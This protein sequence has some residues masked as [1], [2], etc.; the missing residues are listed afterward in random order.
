MKNHVLSPVLLN[1][2]KSF[3]TVLTEGYKVIGE[4]QRKQQKDKHQ[5]AQMRTSYY[6]ITH[7]AYNR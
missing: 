7:L 4:H 1:G 6:P 5:A 3:D 2:S